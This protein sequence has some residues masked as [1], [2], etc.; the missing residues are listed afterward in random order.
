LPPYGRLAALIISGRD[1]T[2]VEKIARTLARRAPRIVGVEVFGP[3]PAALAMVRRRYRWR[4]LLKTTRN[5]RIQSIISAWLS[6]FKFSS[7]TPL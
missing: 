6:S 7:T 4:L 1:A 3:A 5:H 2:L